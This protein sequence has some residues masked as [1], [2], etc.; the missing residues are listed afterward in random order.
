MNAK[1]MYI[2]RSKQLAEDLANLQRRN[3]QLI[4]EVDRLRGND[5]VHVEQ[6]TPQQSEVGEC[7]LL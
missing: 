3:H 6:P 1:Q 5:F 7:I 4:E 2:S